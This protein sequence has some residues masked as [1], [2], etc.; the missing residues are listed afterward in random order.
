[1]DLALQH[2]N[3]AVALVDVGLILLSGETT[4]S[5]VNLA[6]FDAHIPFVSNCESTLPIPG[7]HGSLS[8]P[9]RDPIWQ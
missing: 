4:S 8:L 7:P 3:S 9:M 5:H 6:F 2:K 1:M